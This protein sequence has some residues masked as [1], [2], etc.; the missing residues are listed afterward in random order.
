M[1]KGIVI[2]LLGLALI[3]IVSPGIVGRIA[4]RS[5]DENIDWAASET[6]ELIVTSQ[7][8]DRG[9]FSSEGQHRVELGDGDLRELA[10]M[11]ADDE[12]ALPTLIIDTRLDHGLIPV[13][14]MSRD[15]GSLLPG[16]GSAVSTLSLEAEGGRKVLLPGT[17]YSEIG[18]TGALTS[19]YI[20]P[21]GARIDD[22]GE[23]NWGDIDIKV[24]ANPANGALEFAGDIASLDANTLLENVSVGAARFDGRQQPTRFGVPL[25]NLQASLE[26]LTL[27]QGDDA[28]GAMGAVSIGPVTLNTQT[29]LNDNRINNRSTWK[30]S[31]LPLGLF[32]SAGMDVDLSLTGLDAAALGR[33]IEAMEESGRSSAAQRQIE[34]SALELLSAGFDLQIDRFDINTPQ[35]NLTAVVS[36]EVDETNQDD[37]VWTQSLLATNAS[38][39]I[40]VSEALL[41]LLP[42]EANLNLIIG[43]GYLRKN[44]DSYEMEATFEKGLLTINGA[45]VQ[46][47]L[48]AMR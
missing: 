36:V 9:W 37:A 14:S 19:N 32:E 3:I 1:K 30:A 23:I 46:I 28:F 26:S 42:V 38:A 17:V 31:N 44:G 4:E 20:L 15:K 29:E 21:A 5:M 25:L 34:A 18:L 48:G 16:L 35:G 11:V 40:S 39:S 2:I 27:S 45:P 47:P 10:L 33:L 43:L 41:D 8:F 6:P 13:A 12:D 22:D 24:T 7:A